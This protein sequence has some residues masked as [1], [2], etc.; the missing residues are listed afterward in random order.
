MLTTQVRDGSYIF[1][2]LVEGSPTVSHHLTS[3]FVLLAGAID[4][5]EFIASTINLS[6]MQS[7]DNLTAVFEEFD[8]DKS[9]PHRSS[10]QVAVLLSRSPRLRRLSTGC[11]ADS[12]ALMCLQGI[13]HAMSCMLH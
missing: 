9:G 5:E 6:A 4:I 8:T 11:S 10:S 2:I 7:S 12:Q 3:S 13:C 1:L